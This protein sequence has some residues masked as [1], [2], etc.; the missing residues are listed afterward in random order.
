MSSNQKRS[1]GG[2]L[3]VEDS[4][5]AFFGGQSEGHLFRPLKQ[6]RPEP[7]WTTGRQ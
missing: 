2:F 7:A 6:I 3:S 4:G 5:I 1:V